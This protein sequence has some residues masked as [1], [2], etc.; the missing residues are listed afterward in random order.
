M[1]NLF[2]QR[3][4]IILL[5]QTFIL[6]HPVATLA[7]PNNEWN[8]APDIFQVNR[9]PAHA[10]LM[11][12]ADIQS[13]LSNNRTT[14]PYYLALNGTWKFHLSTNP[15]QQDTSFFKDDA[16]VDSWNNIQVP[17][18]WQTQGFDY[19]IYTNVTYPWTGKENPAP[20]NAPTIYNPVGSYRR[21][22][23]LPEDWATWR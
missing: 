7:Q 11:P 6:L 21:E 23:M 17:G 2:M 12:Y 14:S 9:E 3:T 8:N 19:P 10:T 13:A 16:E 18:D 4:T 22:F 5:V 15:S 1:M 20:P